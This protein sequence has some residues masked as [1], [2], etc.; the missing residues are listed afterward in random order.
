MF[1]KKR[2]VPDDFK[3]KH[4]TPTKFP[5]TEGRFHASTKKPAKDVNMKDRPEPK[6]K[7]VKDV[8]MKE[9]KNIIPK[10]QLTNRPIKNVTMKEAKQPKP[11]KAPAQQ[12]VASSSPRVTAQQQQQQQPKAST[13]QSKGD[14]IPEFPLRE[15]SRLDVSMNDPDP[16]RRMKIK[17]GKDKETVLRTQSSL[18]ERASAKETDRYNDERRAEKK[19]ADE[20]IKQK[21]EQKKAEEKRKELERK[22]M[23]EENR[24]QNA[25]Y[26]EHEAKSKKLAAELDKLTKDYQK[27][28]DQMRVLSQQLAASTDARERDQLIA[29]GE[30]LDEELYTLRLYR[31]RVKMRGTDMDEEEIEASLEA[32][33]F[34]RTPWENYGAVVRPDAVETLGRA[35]FDTAS[36]AWDASQGR[37][38]KLPGYYKEHIKPIGP[39]IQQGFNT[40]GQKASNLHSSYLAAGSNFANKMESKYAGSGQ[41]VNNVVKYTPHVAGAAAAT[42]AAV[43][44]GFL[45]KHLVDKNKAKRAAKG[46]GGGA[47]GGGVT[48]PPPKKPRDKNKVNTLSTLLG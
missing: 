35:A 6:P 7:P 11:P 46:G 36:V 24:I 28:V 4:P 31:E 43:G 14:N 30:Q 40:L 48:K 38:A 42:G 16:A 12:P 27:T 23:E 8:G 44:L 17:N 22:Q 9:V 13:S 2:N 25:I 29:Q 45:I 37:F 3:F 33:E 20:E 1:S 5:R 19:K 21:E 39:Q 18:T 26:Q 34:K 32:L 10:T 15:Y 41:Y 47:S